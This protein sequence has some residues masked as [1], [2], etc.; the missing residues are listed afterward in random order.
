VSL[1][2]D[3]AAIVVHAKSICSKATPLVR[4]T[5]ADRKLIV[6]HNGRKQE[7]LLK[8]DQQ[9]RAALKKYFEIVL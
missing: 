5:L 6:T 8:S 9:W 4:I 1:S 2:P 3:F 7:S